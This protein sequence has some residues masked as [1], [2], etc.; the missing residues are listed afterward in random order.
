MGIIIGFLGLSIA[1][2][3]LILGMVLLRMFRLDEDL[4][5]LRI[6]NAALKEEIEQYVVAD[7]DAGFDDDID[8][9]EN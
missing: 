5:N 6:V 1:L 4:A 7:I 2:I 9:L 3:V 8:D